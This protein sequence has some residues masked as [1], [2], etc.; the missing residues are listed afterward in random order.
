MPRPD[1]EQQLAFENLKKADP[2]AEVSWDEQ[3]G[4]PLRLRGNL[5][6]PTP[7]AP[8]PVARAFLSANRALFALRSP[9]AELQLKDSSADRLGN[10]HLRFQQMYQG[11]PVFGSEIV[12][13]LNREN[14]VRGVNGRFTP[15]IDVPKEPRLSAED[16]KKIALR[17]ERNNREIPGKEPVLLVLIHGGK[18]HLCWHLT[19]G[20]S[21]KALDGST[22]PAE[23][24]YFVDALTGKVVWRYNNLP[25]HTR[26]TGAGSG[27]YSGSVTVNTVHNHAANQYELEDQWVPTGA[28]VRT[29]D[30]NNGSPPSAVSSDN[31]NS[32]S[33][34]DQGPEVDCHH[35]SRIVFDYYLMVHGRNS[36]DDGGADMV[37][38][39]HVGNNWN[40]A[41]WSPSQQLVKIGDGDGTTYSPFST[42]D[43]VAHEWTHAV[44]EHTAGLIYSG[45]S[46]AINESMSDVFAALIDGDWL[47]GEDNWLAASAPA[48]RNLADPTNGGQYDPANPIVSVLA[49]HQ[50]DH[51]NDRYTGAADNGGVHINS[52]IVNKAAFLIATGG[53][54][55]GISMCEALGNEVLGRLY[56]QALTSHLTA[57][58]NFSDMRDAVLDSL[59]DLYA[60]DP[61]YG[62]WRATI[63]NA[64]AAVGIGTATTCPLTCWIAP[65]ICPPAPTLL[66]P[67]SPM[68]C[69]AAPTVTCPPAP[70]LCLI[71][72]SLQC[73][74]A[75][76]ATC[77]PSPI[78]SC[79]P[80]PRF[81]CP[82]APRGC[83]PGPDPGPFIPR[84]ER[85]LPVEK[86]RVDEIPG[87]G[88]E[89][90]S[91]LKKKGISTVEKL[92]QATDSAKR[93][94]VLAAETGI[95]PRSLKNWRV[96]AMLLVSPEK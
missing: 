65:G 80:A 91:L 25:T 73:P 43:M 94:N 77:P 61:R 75:P 36:Y 81:I 92:V 10:R 70:T 96:K 66:C 3:S 13:H 42:L 71:S 57:S 7:G 27:R 50:P 51:W 82:P 59:D 48:G 76:L 17:D 52:G 19:V 35:Y 53:I 9:E 45:E 1:R 63:I 86:L 78:L 34:A 79:P 41:S 14:A 8:E 93:L 26:T 20:G 88:K 56:Y 33:A 5:S 40:N 69:G 12:V 4:A 37:I 21:D 15:R 84:L 6:A 62:R 87:I 39:A 74:P 11:L 44:T 83:L 67:P 47:H 31:N 46:G 32:W 38:N 2:N 23:W 29:H 68:L 55:R 24:A 49:G 22:A 90:A 95:S 58:S 64:F 30:S 54:H 16:A 18:P 89:S 60:G 85:R 72:P 28:R